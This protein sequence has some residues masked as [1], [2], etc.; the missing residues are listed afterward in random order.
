MENKKLK[1]VRLYC[2]ECGNFV[3]KH[4]VDNIKN[5][6]ITKIICKKCF[7][8]VGKNKKKTSRDR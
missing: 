6:D 2:R 7:N 8:G 1:R 4:K 3:I 5:V